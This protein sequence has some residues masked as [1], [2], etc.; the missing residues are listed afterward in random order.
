MHRVDICHSGKVKIQCSCKDSENVERMLS[1]VKLGH[2]LLIFL[3]T[4]HE[5]PSSVVIVRL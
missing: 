3:Y 4:H 1:H 5:S 2:L